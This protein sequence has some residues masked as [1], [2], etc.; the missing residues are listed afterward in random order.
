MVV[1]I[2]IS[3]PRGMWARC[4]FVR[5]G[6]FRTRIGASQPINRL[7]AESQRQIF[8][9]RRLLSASSRFARSRQLCSFSVESVLCR[10]ASAGPG[11]HAAQMTAAAT[12]S[13]YL[14]ETS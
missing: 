3:G 1:E 11:G 4:G 6:G 13:P 14:H 12:E 8:L 5:P 7:C 2:K 10:E 9:L